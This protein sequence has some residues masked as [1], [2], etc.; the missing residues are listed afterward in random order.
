[1]KS[2]TEHGALMLADISGFTEFVTTTA[3]EHGPLIIAELL[4]Q[5]IEQISPPLEI[6]EIEGDAVFALGPDGALAPPAS[7]LDLVEGAF[8]AFRNRRRELAADQSCPCTACR[9]LAALDLKF[10]VHHGRF[11]RHAIGG[12][13]QAAGPDVILAHRLLK[14]GLTGRRGYLLLTEAALRWAA[15][16]PGR[17]DLIPHTEH[18]DY[19]GDVRCF[20][21][22]LELDGADAI[23]LG[24]G[25]PTRGAR[26]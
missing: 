23:T 11:L 7:V 15:L 25:A 14:N 10:V 9:S 3:I 8:A 26:P 12:W 17:S 4:K 21:R 18:Y 19:L 6:Q 5:V 1:M 24:S 16:D 2:Y 22:D 13:S 20:V